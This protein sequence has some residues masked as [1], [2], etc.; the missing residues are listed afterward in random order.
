MKSVTVAPDLSKVLVTIETTHEATP[1]EAAEWQTTDAPAPEELAES[2]E[3]LVRLRD[4]NKR[5]Y[6]AREGISL[7]YV[8][9]VIKAV[10]DAL[11]SHPTFNAH[12][13]D[14]GLLAK[15]RQW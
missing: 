13:T 7:S 5:E 15:R 9:F 10:V 11:R 6:Q 8:P 4:S 3:N 2:H 14:Q 1:L 12:W